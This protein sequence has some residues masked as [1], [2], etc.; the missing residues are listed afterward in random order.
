MRRYFYYWSFFSVP[1]RLLS[2]NYRDMSRNRKAAAFTQTLSTKPSGVSGFQKWQMWTLWL[3]PM[4]LWKKIPEDL[5]EP[6]E[7]DAP[8]GRT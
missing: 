7:E 6:T 8:N 3:Q 4:P 2:P 5:V 1:S